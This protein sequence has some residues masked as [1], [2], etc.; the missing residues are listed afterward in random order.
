MVCMI[1]LGK[2]LYNLIDLRKIF[3][4]KLEYIDN[5]LRYQNELKFLNIIIE[6]IIPIRK[7]HN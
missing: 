5:K 1:T 2:L 7:N 3:S 4:I 6:Y